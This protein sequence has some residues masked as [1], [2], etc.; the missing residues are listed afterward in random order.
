MEV[1]PECFCFCFNSLQ[2]YKGQLHRGVVVTLRLRRELAQ[3][4]E[5]GEVQVRHPQEC[6][7]HLRLISQYVCMG[8]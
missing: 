6:A 7:P 8:C 4:K 3:M 5:A 1:R 2:L